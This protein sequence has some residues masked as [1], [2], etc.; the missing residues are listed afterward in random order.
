MNQ[1]RMKAVP[2]CILCKIP[3][4]PLYQKLNDRLLGVLGEFNIKRCPA[5]GLLWLDPRPVEE[6]ITH[7]YQSRYFMAKEMSTSRNESM[8]PQKMARIDSIKRNFTYGYFRYTHLVDNRFY[9][10]LGRILG[11]FPLVRSW[12]TYG[13]DE[14]IPRYKTGQDGLIIDVGCGRGNYLNFV[15]GLGWKVQGVEP[16]SDA[17]TIAR[18]RGIP[19]FHGTLEQAKFPAASADYII[20]SHVIEHV[21]DPA[22]AI[23]ECFRVLK[24]QGKLIIHTP[25]AASFGHK[26]F[27]KD[28]Y[29]LDPPRH[30]FLFSPGSA[31]KLLHQSRLKK[32]H[33]RTSPKG[34]RNIYDNS[35]V[36]ARTGTT[37]MGGVECQKG[38]TLFALR[39]LLLY[40]IGRPCGEEMEIVAY[41]E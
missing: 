33:L 2:D 26:V 37:R 25:N 10:F 38:H 19:V 4:K 28:Y 36:I 12:A 30:L 17:A 34:C 18:N 7:C 29:A 14:R 20:L 24:R 32:F 15:Q 6:D 31:A 11:V 35:V 27:G 13:A 3:G 40:L 1:I 21:P 22:V 41:K 23:D 9:A 39:E 5:C 16:S 8:K